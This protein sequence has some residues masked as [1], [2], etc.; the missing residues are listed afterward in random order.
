M[1]EKD[2]NFSSCFYLN[3]YR[4]VESKGAFEIDKII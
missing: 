1:E 2:D 4:N 3:S